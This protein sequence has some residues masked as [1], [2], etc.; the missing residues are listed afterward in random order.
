MQLPDEE[1]HSRHEHGSVALDGKAICDCR[2]SANTLPRI[3][4]KVS[5][6]E[7]NS[8]RRNDD[9]AKAGSQNNADR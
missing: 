5:D 2:L 7:Y 1:E 4:P 9:P 8:T 6:F 3:Q